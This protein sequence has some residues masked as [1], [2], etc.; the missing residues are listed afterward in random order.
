MSSQLKSEIGER[1][2]AR[3]SDMGAADV[4][5]KIATEENADEPDQ[6]VE[7]LEKVGHP[8]LTMDALF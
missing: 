8:A 5:D 7:Y 4:F 1:L 2:K 6:L 3:L